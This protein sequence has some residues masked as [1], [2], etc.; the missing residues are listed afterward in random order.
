MA[1]GE[2]AGAELEELTPLYTPY[3]YLALA[4]MTALVAFRVDRGTLAA[5]AG[6]TYARVRTAAIVLIFIIALTQLLLV[7][8]VNQ[9]DLPSIP[10]VLGEGFA[11]F[12]GDVFVVFAPFLGALGSFMTGS[13]TVSNLLF[14]SLQQD[15]AQALD[16]A[17]AVFRGLQL[18]GAGV[19]NMISLSNIAMASGAAGLESREGE[20][21]RETIVPVLVVCLVAGA[22]LFFW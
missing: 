13:A 6:A 19:G 12:L 21:I 1:F 5:A 16:R 20:V 9:A 17:V 22:A 18:I 15:A 10:Q 4:F 11:D 2:C 3:F 7:S 8:D 14:A